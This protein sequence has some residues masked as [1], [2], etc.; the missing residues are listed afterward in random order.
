MK[1]KKLMI[2]ILL[3]CILSQRDSIAGYESTEQEEQ[4]ERAGEEYDA[5]LTTQ[6]EQTANIQIADDAYSTEN[7][8]G[9]ENLAIVND[10]SGTWAAEQMER[11]ASELPQVR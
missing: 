11:N 8:E 4:Q 7:Q 9:V 2:P 10:A 6:A 5:Y 3:L 1:H